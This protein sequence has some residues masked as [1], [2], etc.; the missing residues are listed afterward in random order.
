MQEPFIAQ[1]GRC[2]TKMGSAEGKG[3]GLEGSSQ[4]Q[5]RVVSSTGLEEGPGQDPLEM[6]SKRPGEQGCPLRSRLE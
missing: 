5:K 2:L 6:Q 4:L 3:E 1:T